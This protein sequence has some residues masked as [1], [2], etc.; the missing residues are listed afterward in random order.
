MIEVV[1]SYG[2]RMQLQ[3]GEVGHP[4]ERG[5]RFW[6]ENSPSRFV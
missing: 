4:E 3:T 6:K 1:G 5:A 2:V